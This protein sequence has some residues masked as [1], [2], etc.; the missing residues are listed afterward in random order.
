MKTS[1]SFMTKE[2]DEIHLENDDGIIS[3]TVKTPSWK[4]P[5]GVVEDVT[6]QLLD[7][8]L[9]DLKKAVDAIYEGQF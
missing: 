3:L 4:N 8:D 1:Y 6:I 7:D 9:M 5:S 2:D